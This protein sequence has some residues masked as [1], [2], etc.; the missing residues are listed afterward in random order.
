MEE[1]V[2]NDTQVIE[3]RLRSQLE[4]M[5]RECQDRVFSSYR[6]G[7]VSR[8]QTPLRP[9][10]TDTP[11]QRS[12]SVQGPVLADMSRV[13][14]GNGKDNPVPSSE[15]GTGVDSGAPM[16]SRHALDDSGYTSN[17]S[18][19]APSPP[20][21]E[22]IPTNNSSIVP[23]AEVEAN[24]PA[25]VSTSMFNPAPVLNPETQQDLTREEAFGQGF[26]NSAMLGC[27]FAE[28]DLIDWTSFLSAAPDTSLP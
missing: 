2:H 8:S 10:N 13:V 16:F 20:G 3:D 21:S 1:V 5:I 27:D 22:I 23:T 7:S 24:A 18:G 12:T 14:V 9:M 28:L 19:L 15:V 6:S 25:A 26:D 17:S 4:G 11:T